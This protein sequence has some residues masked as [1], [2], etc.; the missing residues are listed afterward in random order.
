MGEV[1][2]EKREHWDWAHL[3][4]RRANSVGPEFLE[5]MTGALNE[6]AKYDP[7]AAARPVLLTGQGSALSAGL[8]LPTLIEYDRNQM[9]A[10]LASFDEVFGRIATLPRPTLVAVNGHAVAGG[11]V[12][13]LACDFRVAAETTPSGK[14]YRF[15]LRESAIGLPLPR[16]VASI[17]RSAIAAGSTRYEVV[18]TG[19]LFSP[20]EALQRRMVDVVVPADQLV[21]ETER[22]AKRFAQS[23]GRAAARLK[24]QFKTELVDSRR[25]A[26]EDEAFLDSWFSTETQR[27]LEEVVA[28]LRR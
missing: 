2:I 3:E 23:T 20:A 17:V 13:A 16:I 12:L 10:F 19:D 28:R 7:D 1:R 9:R 11:A 25:E 6:L 27:R 4:L 14:G 18:L 22:H 26:P 8:D 21:D 24:E 15:G 5:A